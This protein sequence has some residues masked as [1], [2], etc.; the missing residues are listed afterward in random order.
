MCVCVRARQVKDAIPVPGLLAA[1]PATTR[2]ASSAP[3]LQGWPLPKSADLL[4]QAATALQPLVG[5]A[6]SRQ[7]AQ[8]THGL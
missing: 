1:L 4:M 5:N 8:V 6:V 2:L 3:W 7:L